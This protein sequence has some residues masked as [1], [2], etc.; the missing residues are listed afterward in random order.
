MNL[1]KSKLLIDNFDILNGNE[2]YY[3][4]FNIVSILLFVKHKKLSREIV[5]R[6]IE[7]LLKIKINELKENMVNNEFL[8]RYKEVYNKT[9][10]ILM[11]N[12]KHEQK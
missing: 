1:L 3:F 5:N 10:D 6:K 12:I 8:K 2:K 4:T 11:R 9:F 7:K